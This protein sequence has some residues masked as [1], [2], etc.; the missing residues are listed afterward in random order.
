MN[1]A[2]KLKTPADDLLTRNLKRDLGAEVVELFDTPGITEIGVNPMKDNVWVE[3]AGTMRETSIMLSKAH[4]RS[5]LNRIADS[6]DKILSEDDPH[7][8]A[9]LPPGLFKGARLAGQVE[10]IV[11]GPCFTIRIPPAEPFELGVYIE[12][13]GMTPDQYDT[14][15]EAIDKRW[16]IFVV[17]GTSSGKTTLAMAVLL[18]VSRR[19]PD[20]RIVTIEDTPE[21][22]VLSWC[23]N[24]LYT[25]PTGR[26]HY[27]ELIRM[28]LRM[29][30]DR[31]VVGECRGKS[32]VSLFDAL[33]SGHPG[34]V[35]TFHAD[36][37]EQAFLRML[38][39]AR[40]QSDTDSHKYTIG[41][42]I[43]LMIV[44][45]KVDGVRRIVEMV[46]VDG[47]DDVKGKYNVTSIG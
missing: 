23:W 14:I 12:Q 3:D 46:Y 6:K 44:L 26:Y 4:V 32:I 17:G 34:G 47:Y 37:S 45:R 19:H 1:P 39:Y 40:R 2:L 13:G 27:D 24:P 15:V 35:S 7:L 9:S 16:N 25:H 20:Q 43:D 8:E 42:A 10:P 29:N 31:I 30:P 36:T 22:Q 18:E 5:F 33:L 21:L 28:A 11:P 41:D 38:N